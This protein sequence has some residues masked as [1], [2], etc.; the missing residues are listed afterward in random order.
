ML[1][2][3]NRMF[4]LLLGVFVI[5]AGFG[6]VLPQTSA[7]V[8]AAVGGGEDA[9]L[10]I[11][12]LTGLYM[13]AIALFAPLW[14]HLSDHRGRRMVLIIGLVGFALSMGMFVFAQTLP[15]LYLERLLSGAFAAAIAPTAAAYVS[16]IA[17]SDRWRSSRLAWLNM[18]SIAGFLLGPAFISILAGAP[19]QAG[20]DAGPGLIGPP[21]VTAIGALLAAALLFTTQPATGR[22]VPDERDSGR[23][24][25]GLRMTLLSLSF[26]AALVVGAFEVGISVPRGE[27]PE[28]TSGQIAIMFL[29]CSLVMFGVQALLFSP[30]VRP[31]HTWRVLVPSFVAM[32]IALTLASF[33]AAFAGVASAV[34]LVAASAGAAMP[35]LAYWLSLS[36]GRNKGVQLGRQTM[37]V[38]LGQAA[39]SAGAG[40]LFNA[41]PDGFNPLLLTAMVAVAAAFAAAAVSKRLASFASAYTPAPAEPV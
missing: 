16:D 4:A 35:T 25:D 15:Q 32:A 31:D 29:I 34:V 11:G 20:Q 14:G 24:T 2:L 21:L 28:A 40:A 30:L 3:V 37:A 10:H 12:A 6:L 8:R 27:A 41:S 5:S 39:G 7:F 22:T 17:P 33:T 13:L 36:A 1:K 38:S 18:A 19:G 26:V 9:A 23:K